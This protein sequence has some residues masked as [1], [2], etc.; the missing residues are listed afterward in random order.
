MIRRL[1]EAGAN[2]TGGFVRDYLIRGEC[3]NDVDF[4]F[5]EEP[6]WI[7]QWEQNN[8]RF[9]I[10]ENC[11]EYHC[12]RII[13]GSSTQ[14]LSC[15][16]F[17][18]NKDRGIFARPSPYMFN[19]ELGFKMLLNKQFAVLDLR[20]AN[21]RFKMIERGW[22]E[23]YVTKMKGPITAPEHGSWDEHSKMARERLEE[24]L[25]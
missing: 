18:F 12:Q 4:Y 9:F 7:R 21:I 13:Q 15:N 5:D 23:I 2:F 16:M 8:R 6:D 17:S 20:D 3:F 10:H 22:T 11:I 24:L 1:Y 14:D 19:Y 25:T